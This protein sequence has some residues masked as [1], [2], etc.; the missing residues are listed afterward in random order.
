MSDVTNTD[1]NSRDKDASNSNAAIGQGKSPSKKLFKSPKKSVRTSN[2]GFTRNKKEQEDPRVTE[3]YDYLRSRKEKEDSV[4]SKQEKD[5][6]D[7]FGEYIASKLKK[8]NGETQEIMMHEIHQLLFNIKRR[9][10]HSSQYTPLYMQQSAHYNP[11]IQT[12]NT[13][14]GMQSPVTELHD[15]NSPSA[16][17]STFSASVSP[18]STHSFSNPPT[19]SGPMYPFYP[20]SS[21]TD[22]SGDVTS[23]NL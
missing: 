23:H 22:N 11:S 20:V 4:R 16:S 9:K 5:E 15:L 13:F 21:A 8:E 7:I 3:A 14:L 17:R 10:T 18:M 12:P 6:C 2:K 1:E 19:P